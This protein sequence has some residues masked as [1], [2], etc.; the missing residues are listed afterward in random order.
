MKKAE[1]KL[2]N[3]TEK[4]VDLLRLMGF[5]ALK[6]KDGVKGYIV[7]YNFQWYGANISLELDDYRFAPFKL[8]NFIPELAKHMFQEGKKMQQKELQKVL[9]L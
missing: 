8:K 9:G 1:V 5:E 2:S 4:E 7:R 6:R 3:L